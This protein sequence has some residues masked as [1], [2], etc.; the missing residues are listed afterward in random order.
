M[1]KKYDNVFVVFNKV[2][3]MSSSKLDK[4]CREIMQLRTELQQWQTAH[5][6]LK[7]QLTPSVA[8]TPARK[9][10]YENRHGTSL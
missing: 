6:Y 5:A 1:I 4:M 8:D 2:A 10:N 3:I 9:G 7:S